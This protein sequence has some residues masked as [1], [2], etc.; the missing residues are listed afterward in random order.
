MFKNFI[1]NIDGRVTYSDEENLYIGK[2]HNQII[3]ELNLKN[4][5]EIL[6]KE[7]EQNRIEYEKLEDKDFYKK[8]F[9]KSVIFVVFMFL[10]WYIGPKMGEL[11]HG[12]R[13]VLNSPFFWVHTDAMAMTTASYIL[14]IPISIGLLKSRKDYCEDNIARLTA[15]EAEYEFLKNEL[16]KKEASLRKIEE[17]KKS[18]A[19]KVDKEIQKLDIKTY[20]E[21]LQKKLAFLVKYCEYKERIKEYEKKGVL[22]QELENMGMTPEEIDLTKKLILTK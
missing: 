12:V 8:S 15:L 20:K 6:N 1:R 21:E 17:H 13:T 5:I 7:I 14:L 22:D 3:E 11:I 10:F 18:S 9:R 4:E 16:E 19:L 2:N